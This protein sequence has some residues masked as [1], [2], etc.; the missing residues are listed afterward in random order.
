L[1]WLS[2]SAGNGASHPRPGAIV[3]GFASLEAMGGFGLPLDLD[4]SFDQLVHA[5]VSGLEKTSR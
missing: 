5:F 1:V 3:P 2:S 4:E